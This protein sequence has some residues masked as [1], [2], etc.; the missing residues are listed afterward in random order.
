MA[1]QSGYCRHLMPPLAGCRECKGSGESS[2][3]QCVNGTNSLGYR[4][5]YCGGDGVDTCPCR[6]RGYEPA[7]GVESLP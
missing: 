7:G 4:C 5:P 2:C 6:F 1:E 3:G